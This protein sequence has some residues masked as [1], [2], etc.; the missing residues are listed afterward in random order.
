MPNLDP[1]TDPFIRNCCESGPYELSK[2]VQLR[3]EFWL[4]GQPYSLL[5]MLAGISEATSFIG[6]TVYQAFL[7][8]LSYHCWHAPV[9][10]TIRKIIRSYYAENY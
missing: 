3:S 1:R 4:K 8:A 6:G 7:S 9:D 10:G 2:N 5:D